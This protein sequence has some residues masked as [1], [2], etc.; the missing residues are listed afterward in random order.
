M[1][2]AR[3]KR[4]WAQNHPTPDQ[5][6]ALQAREQADRQLENANDMHA[7]ALSLAETLRQVRQRN[8][9]GQSLENLNW[10]KQ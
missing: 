7:E 10:S 3:V 9:F 8:H 5:L 4:R 1:I 6:E 2:W